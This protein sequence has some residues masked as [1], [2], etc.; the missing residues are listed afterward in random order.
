MSSTP[1]IA[2]YRIGHAWFVT[3]TLCFLYALSLVDRLV[4]SL[5]VQPIT[6]Q[7]H[8]SDGQMGVMFGAGFGVLYAIIGMP[9]AHMLDNHNRIRI[10]AIGVLLWSLSTITSGFATSYWQLV[11]CRSGVAIGEAVLSPAA[12]S[13]IADMFLREKRTLPTGLYM[14]MASL[15]NGAFIIAGGAYR[16]A[17]SLA[18]S[19]GLQAWQLT[20][21]IVGLPGVVVALLLWASAPEP[22]RIQDRADPRSYSTVRQAVAY[23]RTEKRLYGFLFLANCVYTAGA[24]AVISW[25]PT[26]LVRGYGMTPA[27]AGYTFGLSAIVG[28]IGAI[29]WPALAGFF[30]RRNRPSMIAVA[31]AIGMPAGLLG[32]GLIGFASTVT[33]VMAAVALFVIG[34]SSS[35]V[36]YAVIIQYVAPSKV[37]GRLMAANLMAP[38]LVGL[39][40]GPSLAAWLAVHYFTGSRAYG[41]AFSMIGFIAAPIVLL[42]VLAAYGRFSSVYKFAG[43]REARALA[44]LLGDSAQEATQ[45]A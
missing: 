17:Q 42:L 3:W 41:S 38:N 31:L 2:P 30:M 5:L 6:A 11:G 10:L 22:L 23:V 20:F 12:I 26:L 13:L 16:L 28:V 18:P 27:T 43:E 19:V 24:Y 37:R 39:I 25:A 9:V 29:F 14:A 8:I 36:L 35:Q 4:P 15:I 40:V 45:S 44:A 1:G 7:L 21:V 33:G 32:I 34:G